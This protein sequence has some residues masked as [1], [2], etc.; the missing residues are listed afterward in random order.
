[1]YAS[2]SPV[3]YSPSFCRWCS[4]AR[5]FWCVR[6]QCRVFSWKRSLRCDEIWIDMD[7][8]AATTVDSTCAIF[9]FAGRNSFRASRSENECR[10]SCNEARRFSRFRCACSYRNIQ[11]LSS[12]WSSR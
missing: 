6:S 2:D 9:P 3:L 11:M 8:F 12:M 5:T 7:S 4:I 1:M 10:I